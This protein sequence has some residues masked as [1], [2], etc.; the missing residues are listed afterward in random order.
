MSPVPPVAT[1][2]AL[3]RIAVYLVTL[4]GTTNLNPSVVK[5]TTG[6]MHFISACHNLG[7]IL[8]HTSHLPL[9]LLPPL[10]LRHMAMAMDMDMVMGMEMVMGTEVVLGTEMVMGTVMGT[11]IGAGGPWNLPI[12]FDQYGEIKM[13]DCFHFIPTFDFSVIPGSFLRAM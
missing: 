10:L 8:P 3:L 1:I 7:L 12:A 5:A 13:N 6:T 4:R 2:G 11:V 9:P